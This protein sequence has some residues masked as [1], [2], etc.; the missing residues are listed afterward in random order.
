VTGRDRGRWRPR[1]RTR[2]F[3]ADERGVKW[4]LQAYLFLVVVLGAVVVAAST[5]PTGD[6]PTEFHDLQ[7]EHLAEDVLS[8]TGGTGALDRA[9]LHWN[10]SADR[11][12]AADG[13]ANDTTYTTLRSHRAYP[14]WPA[15]NASL[16]GRPLGYNLGVD[17]QVDTDGDGRADATRS[18]WVVYQGP[19]GSDAVTVGRTVHLA[20]DDVPARGPTSADGDPCT[21]AEMGTDPTVGTGSCRPGAFFAPDTAPNSTRYNVLDVHLTVW[22]T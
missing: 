15:V 18:L 6:A 14:L 21:L 2:G 4:T 10:A 22:N 3:G 5:V 13:G 12:V 11:W 20:D 9:V 17:Y 19:A 1:P 8:T 16:V 7:R